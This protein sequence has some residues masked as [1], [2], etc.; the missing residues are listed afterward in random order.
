METIWKQCNYPTIGRPHNGLPH[1]YY[2]VFICIHLNKIHS[3]MLIKKWYPFYVWKCVCVYT[4]FRGDFYSLYF[5]ILFAFWQYITFDI[6]TKAINISMLEK[7]Q[8]FFPSNLAMLRPR[9]LNKGGRVLPM[10]S[11]ANFGHQTARNQVMRGVAVAV[12][13]DCTLNWCQAPL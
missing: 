5:F 4:E 10:I 9:L 2:N 3:M 8:C 7:R 6:K 11:A 12:N 13:T 1:S